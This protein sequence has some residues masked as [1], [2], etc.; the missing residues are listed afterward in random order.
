MELLATIII[1]QKVQYFHITEALEN[2]LYEA[3]L[4]SV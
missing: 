1:F 2:N 4:E 3:R